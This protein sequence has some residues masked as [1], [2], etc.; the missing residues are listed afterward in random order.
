MHKCI[1]TLRLKVYWTILYCNLI[2]K[3][4]S[5]NDNTIKGYN[6]IYQVKGIVIENMLDKDLRVIEKKATL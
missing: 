2:V 1:L 4:I 6:C 3:N 5:K